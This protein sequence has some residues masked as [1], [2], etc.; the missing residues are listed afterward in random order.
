MHKYV[1]SKIYL[2]TC[3]PPIFLLIWHDNCSVNVAD[4]F[5]I[6]QKGTMEMKKGKK[7]NGAV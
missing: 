1:Q 6:K 7:M 3:K 5:K 4:F 2:Y